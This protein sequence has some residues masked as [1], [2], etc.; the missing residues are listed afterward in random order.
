[1]ALNPSPGGINQTLH[2]RPAIFKVPV[3]IMGADVTHPSPSDMSKKPS[4]AAVVGSCD[5]QASKW[6]RVVGRVDNCFHVKNCNC[7]CNEKYTLWEPLKYLIGKNFGGQKCCKCQTM[8][9]KFYPSTDLSAE[10][11]CWLVFKLKK[12]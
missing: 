1:M 11:F 10:I 6:S 12:F 7:E 3:M 4:I 9:I 2:N 5:P 8:L